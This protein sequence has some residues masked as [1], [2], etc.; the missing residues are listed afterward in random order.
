MATISNSGVTNTAFS[1]NPDKVA[2]LTGS[3]RP[4]PGSVTPTYAATV[5]LNSYLGYSTF[6]AMTLTG[7]LT[8]TASNVAAAGAILNIQLTSDGTGRTATF[9]TGFRVTGTLAGTASQTMGIIFV[10]DGTTWNEMSRT[11]AYA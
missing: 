10:S 4:V 9:S 8:L 7:A 3:G 1:P 11:T 6:I 5:D 2:Q